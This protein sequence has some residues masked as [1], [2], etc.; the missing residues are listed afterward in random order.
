VAAVL[1]RETLEAGVTEPR[2]K[3]R[4]FFDI[5]WL[6]SKGVEWNE[7]YLESLIGQTSPKQIRSALNTKIEQ[8]TQKQQLI[9]QDLLP[10][11]SQPQF[12]TDFVT[13]LDQLRF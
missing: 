4:D 2:F 11:F 3:G 13:H 5:W 12:V 7:E 9:K 8:A 1:T 6:K 10:F